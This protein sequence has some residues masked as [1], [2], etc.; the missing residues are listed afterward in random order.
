MRE[1]I[2]SSISDPN[3]AFILVIVGALG[4]YVEY[5]SPGLIIPGVAG[6]IMLLLG[7]SAPGRQLR[8]SW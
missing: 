6:G 4:I 1:Q 7:L 5:L 2:V 3:I 8:T